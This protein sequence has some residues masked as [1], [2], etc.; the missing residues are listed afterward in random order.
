MDQRMNLLVYPAKDMAAAKNLLGELLGVE[1]Y[2]ES[3]YYTGFRTGELEVGLDPNARHEGPLAYWA[4]DDIKASLQRLIAAGGE[5]VQDVK[6]VGGG[7]LI[8][9]VRDANGNIV[10]LRQQPR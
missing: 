7:L 10:G 1:P 4:T 8:A 9:Q 3:P 6:D 5:T 2:A